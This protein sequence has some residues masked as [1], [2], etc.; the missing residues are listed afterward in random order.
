MSFGRKSEEEKAAEQRAAEELAARQAAEAAEQAKVAAAQ[1]AD[2]AAWVATLPKWEYKI[3]TQ[4]AL[5]GLGSGTIEG[6]EGVLNQFAADGWR[7][8][9]TTMTGKIEQMFAADTNEM[10]VVL[11]RP[12]RMAPAG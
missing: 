1:R 12:R 8:V 7:V 4:S 5:A 10:Y 6:I 9:T 3:L 2:E 11:E